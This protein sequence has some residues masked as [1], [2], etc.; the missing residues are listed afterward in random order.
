MIAD[1]KLNEE[2]LRNGWKGTPEDLERCIN[3]CQPLKES[4]KYPYFR[5]NT[6]IFLHCFEG[7]EGRVDLPQPR[8]VD[9]GHAFTTSAIEKYISQN[10]D[11]NS[12]DKY[13]IEL[14]TID[15]DYENLYKFGFFIDRDGT[16]Q[17]GCYDDVCYDENIKL[18]DSYKDAEIEH[19][20]IDF[21]I[22][23]LP[24][25]DNKKEN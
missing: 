23:E 10:Y 15:F 13:M 17:N 19:H 3:R 16:K 25:I 24:Y 5:M 8:L 11:N 7:Y 6:N 21:S 22:L 1:L 9:Y 12:P 18:L 4:S 20:F 14:G 2:Y